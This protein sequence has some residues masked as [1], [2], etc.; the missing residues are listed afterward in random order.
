MQK[1]NAPAG[2]PE[3]TRSLSCWGVMGQSIATVAP[4][5]TPAVNV[6]VIFVALGGAS[7][8]TYIIATLAILLVALNIIPLAKMFAASGSLSDFVGHGLGDSGRIAAGWMMLL[9]YFSNGIA[10]ISASVAY[11]HSLFDAVGFPIPT[12]LLIVAVGSLAGFLA[13]QNIRLAT[14]L[15]LGL[16]A[17]SMALVILLCFQ[18]LGL[19]GWKGDWAEMNL[20]GA[21]LSGLSSALLM[22]FFSFVG[23]ESAASLGAEA[24]NPL[25]TIPMTLL[26]TPVFSGLFFLFS[27]YVITLGFIHFSMNVGAIDV[28]LDELA[29][30]M[31]RPALG[32]LITVGTTISLF[33]CTMASLV[34]ASRTV[35][36][37]ARNG[38]LPSM[39][40]RLNP[41]THNPRNA[42]LATIG[43]VLPITLAFGFFAKPTDVFDC[44]GTLGTF[45]FISVYFLTCIASPLILK[46]RKELKLFHLAISGIAAIVLLG[47]LF[48]SIVPSPSPPL[49][50]LPLVFCAFVGSGILF[51]MLLRRSCPICAAQP[52]P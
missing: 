33:G 52:P 14:G 49:N 36:S 50:I 13:L 47:V 9:A 12:L 32:T 25:R 18:I 16:E 10:I 19:I 2:Q 4:T 46:A 48:A 31:N 3:L 41:Q 21:S 39:L 17:I 22:G 20:K 35:F 30:Q 11:I 6:A 15:M 7:W 43:V 5:A 38:A 51:S 24:K 37:L 45:G 44:L 8:V 23:F 34:A 28:P 40:G 29:K 27:T 42:V 26:A 1:T